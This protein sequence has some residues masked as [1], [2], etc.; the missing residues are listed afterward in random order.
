MLPLAAPQTSLPPKAVRKRK[1]KDPNAPKPPRKVSIPQQIIFNLVSGMRGCHDVGI[2]KNEMR[3]CA[4]LRKKYGDDF[5]L[6]VKPLEGYK[7]ASL[8]FYLSVLGK[9]HLSDQMFEYKKATA[10]QQKTPEMPLAEHKIGEDVA[11]VPKPR[12]LKEFLNYGKEI[13]R[14]ANP[15]GVGGQQQN[16]AGSAVSSN[17]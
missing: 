8:V 6:W 11:V 15:N 13:A 14:A 5:L 4:T 1:P 16:T 7:F 17:V 10:V 12:T 9:N 3:I 2:W